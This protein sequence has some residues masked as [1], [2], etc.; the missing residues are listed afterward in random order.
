[1]KE[2]MPPEESFRLN[3]IFLYRDSKK[4]ISGRGNNI[5]KSIK[6]CAVQETF[7]VFSLSVKSGRDEEQLA[8]NPY[9]GAI[10]WRLSYA[11]QEIEKFLF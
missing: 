1:M 5:Y 10:S 2:L 7:R 9:L 11:V 8:Q 6:K 3:I 4:N